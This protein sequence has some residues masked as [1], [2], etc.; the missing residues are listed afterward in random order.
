MAPHTRIHSLNA[1]LYLACMCVV[2]V[3]AGGGGE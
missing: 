2:V 1:V 3:C